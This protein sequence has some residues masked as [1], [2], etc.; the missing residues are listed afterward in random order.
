MESGKAVT[1]SIKSKIVQGHFLH[2]HITVGP[3]E[4]RSPSQ[5]IKGHPRNHRHQWMLHLSETD[6]EALVRPCLV[7]MFNPGPWKLMKAGIGLTFEQ[8]APRYESLKNNETHQ[9]KTT[10]VIYIYV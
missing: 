3:T 5:D 2:F 8:L 1:I 4:G 7:N 6:L 10:Q 9:N